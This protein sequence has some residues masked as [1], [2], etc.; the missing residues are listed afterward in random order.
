MYSIK[1]N[2]A[3]TVNERTNSKLKEENSY[4]GIGN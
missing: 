2:R 3:V 4:K 1:H